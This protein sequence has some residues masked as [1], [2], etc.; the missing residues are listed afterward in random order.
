[1][2][3]L[4]EPVAV[5][6]ARLQLNDLACASARASLLHDDVPKVMVHF[7]RERKV[8]RLFWHKLDGYHLALGQIVPRAEIREHHH[9]AAGGSLVAPEIQTHRLSV[10]ARLSQLRP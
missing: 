2:P 7:T 10:L 9:G 3:V 6:T 4:D 8:T 1:M 5:A